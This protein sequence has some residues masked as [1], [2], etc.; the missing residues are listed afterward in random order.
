MLTITNLVTGYGKIEILHG[1][2]MLIND[3]QMT[4]VIGPNGAGKSTIFRAIFGIIKV[5]D[6]TISFNGADISKLDTQALLRKGISYVPQGRNIFPLMTIEENL[7]MGAYIRSDK[8]QIKEDIE[9]IY[10]RFPILGERREE[11]ARNLS[12]GQQQMLEMGRSLLLDPDFIMLDEP[13]L[14]LAPNI[15]DKIFKEI[16]K[17][18][19]SGKTIMMVEQNAK[20]ALELADYAYVLELGRNKYEGPARDIMENEK[21]KKL[22]LGG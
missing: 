15:A 4:V 22:Y 19:E 5:W 11:E 3:H 7:E 12:G 20:R 17:I 10:K 6:G 8:N 18:K 9:Q 14:G 21:V 1:V 16:I 13:S 2:N